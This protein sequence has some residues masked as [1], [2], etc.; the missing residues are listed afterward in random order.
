[1]TETIA[2]PSSTTHYDLPLLFSGQA[3]KEFFVNQSFAIIDGLSRHAVES[4]QNEPP[5]VATE[6]QC[7][8]I[9]EPAQG[10][11]SDR[12]DDL[13]IMIGGAWHFISAG[14][15]M[16]IFN[17]AENRKEIF[18]STWL[19]AVEQSPISGGTNIDAEA[20][21]AIAEIVSELKKFGILV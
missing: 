3:Q 10:S 7:F 8:R 9:T 21:T 17:I 18:K 2:F 5:A 16:T 1:M 14:E 19:T 20:R 12:E 13:A 11:W 15:G 6:G 4:A